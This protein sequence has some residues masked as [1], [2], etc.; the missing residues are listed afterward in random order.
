[1]RT[2]EDTVGLVRRLASHYPDDAMIAG[3][4]NRQGKRHRGIGPVDSPPEP[5]QAA[6]ARTWD[7]PRYEIVP[8]ASDRASCVSYPIVLQK[9]SRYRA[10]RPSTAGSTTASSPASRSHPARLGASASTDA[11]RRRSSSIRRSA[12]LRRDAR[13][14][15]SALGVSESD[16]V[17]ACKAGR[18]RR[19]P[20]QAR[21]QKR[22]ENQAPRGDAKPVR[23][24][25]SRRGGSMKRHPSSRGCQRRARDGHLWP[26]VSSG[27]P[28]PSSRSAGGESRTSTEENPPRRPAPAP[29]SPPSAPLGLVP[30]GYPAAV[31]F[32]QPSGCIGGGPPAADTCLLATRRR[33]LRGS[34]RRHTARRHGAIGHRPPRR[35]DSVSLASTLPE[36]RHPSRCDRTARG[37]AFPESAWLRHIAAFAV[38][39]LCR[40][41][42]GRRGR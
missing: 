27:S 7:I 35:R 12:G 39:A 31:S 34:A 4:L 1:M 40:A 8:G 9:T 26:R 23:P 21:T 25:C 3:I 13:R 41:A 24:L 38:V 10:H 14:H 22:A 17:A 6:C 28:A 18:A 29:A 2:D 20:R 30:S 36:G 15:A 19:R 16:G 33:A 32:H 11:L 37:S 5:G 42:Y